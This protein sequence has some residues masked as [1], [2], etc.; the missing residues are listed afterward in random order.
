MAAAAYAD[1]SFRMVPFLLLYLFDFYKTMNTT[2]LDH[3]AALRANLVTQAENIVTKE[4]RI[5]CSPAWTE[6]ELDAIEKLSEERGLAHPQVVR[7]A[8][9]WYQSY[10]VAET[11][12][13]QMPIGETKSSPDGPTPG[14][15]KWQWQG[16]S[17]DFYRLC[18]I[19]G[20]THPAQAHAMKKVIRA[21]K[22]V[23][24]IERD[25]DEAIDALLRWKEM[26]K[27]DGVK[28]IEP[29]PQ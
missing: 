6:A 23:K 14:R 12:E 17:F 4:R 26:L 24:P 5:L 9:R 8:V 28:E 11:Q 16:V 1:D 15:Y 13:E 27:E 19:V 18:G 21:G 22:S 29:N 25:I 7:Q 10:L 2:E 3:G 20:V